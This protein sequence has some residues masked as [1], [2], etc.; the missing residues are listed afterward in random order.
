MTPA[1]AAVDR[2]LT[3][4]GGHFEAMQPSRM[5]GIATEIMATG[6]APVAQVHQYL[7]D[8][9]PLTRSSDGRIRGAAKQLYV[10]LQAALE[11]VP[12]A[13]AG[14]RQAN[15]AARKE[16]A[17][18]DLERMIRRAVHVGNDGFTR[19]DSGRL[20]S[21]LSRLGEEDALFR[22]SFTKDE[23]ERLMGNVY[24]LTGQPQ[25][26]ARPPTVPG[27]IEVRG[28]G[29]RPGEIAPKATPPPRVTEPKLGPPSLGRWAAELA[30]PITE[31]AMHGRVTP[32]AVVASGVAV[33]D[34]TAYG[35]S[36]MFLQP[37]MQPMLRRLIQPGGHVDPRA[38]TIFNAISR[39]PWTMPGTE[40]APAGTP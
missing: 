9:G 19:L 2:V 37:G 28:L 24:A 8:L 36:R 3:Q 13:P 31:V 6:D 38:V 7:K 18:E 30:Y 1:F 32:F 22:G 34:I 33:A 4:L 27:S 20:V 11:T 25:I 26:P 14:L 39:L 5:Q 16:F 10:G 17:V 21:Q 23:W 40:S 35:L 12:G 29:E 15:A